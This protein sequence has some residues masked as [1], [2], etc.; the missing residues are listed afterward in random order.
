[1]QTL[2]DAAIAEVKEETGQ[3]VD[4]LTYIK[5]YYF[6]SLELVMAGFF[7]RVKK[8]EFGRSIEV[9]DL[10]WVKLEDV[11]K[12]IMMENNI[13]GIHFKTV[14]KLFLDGIIK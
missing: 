5:S 7:A 12:D 14:K 1:M 10:R 6:P 8:S 13:S 4:V 3:D 11:E 9:D 2:E